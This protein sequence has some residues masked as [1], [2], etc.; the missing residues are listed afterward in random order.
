MGTLNAVAL[1]SARCPI[2][3]VV[4]GLVVDSAAL[5]NIYIGCEAILLYIYIYIYICVC[6]ALERTRVRTHRQGPTSSAP[7]AIAAVKASPAMH[8]DHVS[9]NNEGSLPSWPNPCF[10][11]AWY[12]NCS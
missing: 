5:H 8:G 3:Q 7:F 10:I 1:P 11:T 2:A 12:C 9:M 4:A 6:I